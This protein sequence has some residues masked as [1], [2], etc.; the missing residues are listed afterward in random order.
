MM[1]TLILL[2]LILVVAGCAPTRETTIAEIVP[3][4]TYKAEREDVKTA[5]RVFCEREGFTVVEEELAPSQAGWVTGRI[6]EHSVPPFFKITLNSKHNESTRFVTLAHELAHVY[7]GHLGGHPKRRW[8]DR[9]A[10]PVETREFEAESAAYIV[11]KRRRIESGSERYLSDYLQSHSEVP[12]LD[13]ELVIRVADRIE[14]MGH[15]LRPP[16]KGESVQEND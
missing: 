8:P 6:G 10:V 5:I 2:L 1:R 16:R 3:F 15:T 9:S 12:P 7:C 11:A 4:K 14:K 13:V